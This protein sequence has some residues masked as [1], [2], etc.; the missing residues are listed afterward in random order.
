MG[1]AFL[2]RKGC[3]MDALTISFSGLYNYIHIIYIQYIYI[4]IS[5]II[6]IYIYNV[7]LYYSHYNQFILI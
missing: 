6:Y 4:Y 3:T 7:F 2:E 5:C 1:R